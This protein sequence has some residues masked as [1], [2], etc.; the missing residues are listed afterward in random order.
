MRVPFPRSLPG[1]LLVILVSGLLI[2]QI[3]TLWIVSQDR[4][5]ANNAL[6][7]YRLTE[8]ATYLVKLLDATPKDEWADLASRMPGSDG[9]LHIADRPSVA[10]PLAPEDDIA[11]LEDVLVARLA[12]YGVIDARIRR[13]ARGAARQASAPARENRGDMSDIERQINSLARKTRSNISLVASLQFNDG[14]WLNF[15]TRVTPVN[16]IITR[17]TIPLFGLVALSVI[18]LAIWAT[19]L[20][21]APYRVLERAVERIGHDLK[22]PPLPETGIREY[23]M[24]ARAVNT[25]QGRLLDYVAER[26]QLAAA[27][28]HDLRTPLT[29]IRL[30]LEL[31]Q[32]E[33][34]SRA[35]AQDLNNIEAISRSVIDFATTELANESKERL[36]L[37]S[38]L[39]SVADD[40]PHV[41][42]DEK[43][44]SGRNGIC[45]CQPVSVRR[46]ITNLIDNAVAYG[47]K[48]KVSLHHSDH[49]LIVRIRDNGPGIA[50]ELIE[51]MFRPF[52]R[53]DKSRNR[54]SGGFGLGL[55][56]AR[57]VARNNGGEIRL[58][59]D[60]AGG[61]VAELS[62]PAAA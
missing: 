6:E 17:A 43:S 45:L 48:A 19:R 47:G 2:T 15:A 57:T 56:I 11:E 5:D 13:E 9:E 40:Y 25:M 31:L 16:P 18:L 39:L 49:E 28:A 7:L 30:R 14:R 60:P 10:A 1:W 24:A 59:N 53:V 8:R 34:L 42:V 4:A 37:W 21:T 23:K 46:C 44:S 35:L 12:R 27:L 62:L 32:D 38:L 26:E 50:P 29:R 51:E 20:L 22:T 3:A 41:A 55:T 61:L 36:N 58:R 52:N 33:A 54:D